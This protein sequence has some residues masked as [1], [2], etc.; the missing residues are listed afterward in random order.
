MS[1]KLTPE[2]MGQNLEEFAEKHALLEEA[3]KLETRT[4]A[5]VL[6]IVAASPHDHERAREI[7]RR[8]AEAFAQDRR[9]REAESGPQ[10]A[11]AMLAIEPPSRS[12]VR[13]MLPL[14]L[15]AGFA[16]TAAFEGSAILAW[17][18]G[19]VKPPKIEDAGPRD[20]RPLELLAQAR[21][22]YAQARWTDC[23]LK[24]S[25]ATS[26]QPALSRNP[27]V[28]EMRRT[29]EQRLLEESTPKVDAS[30]RQK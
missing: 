12:P 27:E 14:G 17:I 19:P 30:P 18:E 13:W 15:A 24:L 23:L 2:E 5:E 3:E 7:G 8:A 4:K 21:E 6:A 9:E 16:M 10:P 25:H 11:A 22:D 29:A 26:L 1:R 20:E 28:M